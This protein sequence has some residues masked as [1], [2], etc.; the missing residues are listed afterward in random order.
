MAVGRNDKGIKQTIHTEL[1]HIT[2]ALPAL[3]CFSRT[4]WQYTQDFSY[5]FF[6][7]SSSLSGPSDPEEARLV[8][9]N[10]TV[11][12]ERTVHSGRTANIF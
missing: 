3:Y 2:K 10:D 7:R 4:E 9:G 12:L 5:S 11:S 8:C 6:P 1:S